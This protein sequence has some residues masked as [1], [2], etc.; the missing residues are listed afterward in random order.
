[1][2]TVYSYPGTVVKACSF[3]F[4]YRVH[5]DQWG[6]LKNIKRH[7][8]TEL[9]AVYNNLFNNPEKKITST[10]HKGLLS[11]TLNNKLSLEKSQLTPQIIDFLKD[12]LNFIS[13]EYLTKKRLVKSVYQV[14]K[15]FKLIEEQGDM[16]FIPCGFLNQGKLIQYIGR[17]RG[18][19]NHKVII[20]YRDS[21]IPFLERQFKQRQ[22]VYK[23][24]LKMGK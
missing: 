22:R 10:A 17:L 7:S 24:L 14:E 20:D 4:L 3:G 12:R 2:Y 23:K 6:F 5:P 9:D 18:Y 8:H 15:Y 1:M 11:I 16:V 19:N 13:S 21:Q